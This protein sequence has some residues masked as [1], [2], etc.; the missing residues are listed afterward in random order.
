MHD[1][2]TERLRVPGPRRLLVRRLG[3]RR[4]G[5]GWSLERYTPI[6]HALMGRM[7]RRQRSPFGHGW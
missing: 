1:G 5:C 2:S 6:K 3:C 4:E 7:T